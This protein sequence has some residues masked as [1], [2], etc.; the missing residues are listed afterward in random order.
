MKKN[1]GIK[2]LSMVVVGVVILI[3]INQRHHEIPT[4]AHLNDTNNLNE[5][6]ASQFNDNIRDVSARLL[7]AK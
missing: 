1:L 3:L 7:E 6:I 4:T 2:M 5:A